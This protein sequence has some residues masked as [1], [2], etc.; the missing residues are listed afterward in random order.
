MTRLAF[1]GPSLSAAEARALDPELVVLPPAG[2]GDLVSAARRHRPTA[3]A[4]IDGTFMQNMAVFHKEILH[5]LSDGIR[6]VGASSMGAIRAAE[7]QSFGMVGVGS[8][9]QGFADG[10]IADDDEVALSHAG[11]ED[12]FRA[13]S[14][15]MVNIRATL[16]RAVTVGILRRSDADTLSR[17]Q[18]QRWFPER[19][20]PAVLTDARAL[21]TL[22]DEALVAL[23]AL[24]RAGGV[25][26]K[27]A[28]AVNAISVLAGLPSDLVEPADRPPMSLSTAYLSTLDRDVSVGAE[29]GSSITFERIRFHCALNDAAFDEV[30]RRS[31][32]RGIL[33]RLAAHVGVEVDEVARA[34]ARTRILASLGCD[35]D[36]VDERLQQ[37]DMTAPELEELITGEAMIL[38][39][40]RWLLAQAKHSSVTK[41]FLNELRLAG[42]Y[43]EVRGQ[44][45]L[46]DRLASD[47]PASHLAIPMGQLVGLQASITGWQVPDDLDAYIEERAL[48]DRAQLYDQLMVSVVALHELFAF[49]LE[50]PPVG[51]EAIP[52]HRA[53]EMNTRG[54]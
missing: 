2:M 27:R 1:L 15:A 13:L 25:N 54:G 29:A 53:R 4:L 42:R 14:E 3:V 31:L 37:L 32:R 39:L 20:L 44:A 36:R 48:G 24:L 12:G 8:V 52:G 49:P 22:D 30:W 11:A 50:E 16:D 21:G 51:A 41:P 19:S 47:S 6:V 43:E 35:P 17:L 23:E 45:D 18:K 26:V 5:L 38:R 7:M 10:S 46:F 9:F 40:E 33:L 28:D 34:G